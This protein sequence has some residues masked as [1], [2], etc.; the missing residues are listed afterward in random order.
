MKLFNALLF[1]GF[2]NT[3]CLGQNIIIESH[4][5]EFGIELKTPDK[6]CISKAQYQSIEEQARINKQRLIRE[7]KWK[8]SDMR[9]AVSYQWP[10]RQAAGFNYNSYYYVSVFL[11]QDTDAGELLDY[12]CGDRTYDGHRGTD[13]VP[14]PFTWHMMN[15]EQVEI[16]AAAAGTIIYKQS[17]YVDDRCNFDFPAEWNGLLIEHG[18]GSRTWYAHMK[19]GSITSKTVGSSVSAGEYLGLIGSSGASTG[20]HL[21]FEVDGGSQAT[22][23][24]P[25]SGSCNS[26]NATSCWASQKSNPDKALNTVKTHTDIPSS[27]SCPT[28]TTTHEANTFIAGSLIYFG[29]YFRDIEASDNYT[30]RVRAPGG[31]IAFQNTY[32]SGDTEPA[33]NIFRGLTFPV[34]VTLGL[35]TVEVDYEGTTVTHSFSITS[36]L[37]VEFTAFNGVL[38]KET[39]LLK[40][41]DDFR[42]E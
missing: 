10:V 12:D 18:D 34:G 22:L 9:S 40:L 29:M 28:P 32:P 37:P 30:L 7:G 5:E 3:F 11:D 20:P 27:N 16:I 36:A 31:S 17:G 42:K 39:V 13:I 2:V 15:D 41:D 1:L 4:S 33:F 21:H 25:Y 6:P 19:T 14:F 35:W 26:L 8:Q 23:R 38:N 24:D